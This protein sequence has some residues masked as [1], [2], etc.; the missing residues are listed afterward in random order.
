MSGIRGRRSEER[1]GEIHHEC[2]HRDALTV[3]VAMQDANG[4][5]STHTHTARLTDCCSA[6]PPRMGTRRC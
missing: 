2:V 1:G 3:A 6:R 4:S 5:V